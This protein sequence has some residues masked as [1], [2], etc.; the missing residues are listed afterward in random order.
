MEKESKKIKLVTANLICKE[1]T[2][3]EIKR[4]ALITVD[5]Q[6]IAVNAF[7][8]DPDEYKEVARKAI[9]NILVLIASHQSN[10]NNTILFDKTLK[11]LCSNFNI[12]IN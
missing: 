4:P 11:E 6:E 5:N 1:T 12:N 3:V 8:Y 9:I 10:E 2:N 7:C